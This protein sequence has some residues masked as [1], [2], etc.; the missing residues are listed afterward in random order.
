MLRTLYI[1]ITRKY[2]ATSSIKKSNY[3]LVKKQPPDSIELGKLKI[4]KAKRRLS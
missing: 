4:I 1:E 3:R 2:T